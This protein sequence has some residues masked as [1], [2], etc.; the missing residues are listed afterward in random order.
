M[1]LV[2]TTSDAKLLTE[3]AVQSKGFWGY[4]KELLSSWKEELTVSETMISEMI[5]FKYLINNQIIGFYILQII[6]P[7][8]AKLEFLFIA[9]KFIG[10]GIGSQLLK[11]ATIKASKMKIESLFV[12]SDP[13]AVV[14]YKNNGFVTVAKKESTIASRFL[15]VMQKDL[16]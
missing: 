9:P 5:V 8:K 11:H 3:I 12:L 14:F 16:A 2:A 7:Q 6:N 10:K 15:P 13:N 4:S 1:I